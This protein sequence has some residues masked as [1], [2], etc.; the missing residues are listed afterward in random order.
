M[1]TSSS[2]S[3]VSGFTAA[4]SMSRALAIT[5]TAGHNALRGSGPGQKLALDSALALEG[6]PDLRIDRICITCC[7]SFQPSH[8]ADDRRDLVH[9]AKATGSL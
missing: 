4:A 5:W 9:A 2:I 8:H 3:G 6:C 1:A 7:S